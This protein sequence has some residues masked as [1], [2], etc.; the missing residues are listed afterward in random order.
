LN[1]VGEQ[2]KGESIWLGWFL[3]ATLTTFAPYAQARG[4]HRR[5]AQWLSHAAALQ[6]SLERFGW[7]GDWY[8]RAYF[9]D[10]TAL[11][12]AANE[13]C[14]IDSI[15]QSWAVISGAAAP[16][17]AARAMSAVEAQLI[18]ADSGLALLFTPPFDH[19]PLN[20]GYIKGY[21]PGLR[22]NGGQYTHAALWLVF[23]Y[24]KLGRGNQAAALLALLNPVNRTRTRADVHRYKVE[25]YAVAADVYSVAPH[26]GRGGWTWYTGSASW[27]YRAGL[28]AIL[29][30]RLQGST[31]LLA[32]C[33]PQQWPK[34]EIVFKYCSARYVI[35]IEN[36]DG[37]S[38]GV[39]HA[40]LDGETLAAEPVVIA[41]VD[42][43]ATHHVRVRLGEP[44]S[45]TAPPAPRTAP[46]AAPTAPIPLD[47]NRL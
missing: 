10:G 19:T 15:A 31:L 38:R 28:E 20:P 47:A 13:E 36:P 46:P 7:D 21:P 29:G 22:E 14:R 45:I 26:T 33:I 37:V 39:V 4:E 18:R 44:G 12:S 5:A 30:F 11:G 24:A 17:R 1:C 8:R 3:H 16:D 6:E 2:G 32:P 27:M 25:P 23:A 40:E 34:A 43:G 41:L 9:D 42:D 35:L